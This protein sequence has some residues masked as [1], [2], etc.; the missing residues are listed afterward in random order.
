MHS[1]RGAELIHERRILIVCRRSVVVEEPTSALRR[2]HRPCK[3]PTLIA[4]VAAGVRSGEWSEQRSELPPDA[5]A[6]AL[7]KERKG[8]NSPNVGLR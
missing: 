4:A 6:L 5:V 7:N 1:P 2:C 3:P 8:L